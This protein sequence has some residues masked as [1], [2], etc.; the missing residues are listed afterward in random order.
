MATIS[1]TINVKGMSCGH[2]VNT[3]E[4]ALKELQGIESVN[5]DLGGNKVSVSFDEQAVGLDKVK[6][7]IEEVGYDVV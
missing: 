2:C 6:E 4:T 3:I 1:T 7:T 5:V